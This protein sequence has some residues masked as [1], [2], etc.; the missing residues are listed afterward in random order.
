MKNNWISWLLTGCLLIGS[1]TTYADPLDTELQ[2]SIQ[3]YLNQNQTSLHISAVQ[4]SVWLPTE[5]Q[6]RDYV[7]GAQYYNQATPATK[8][9]MMQWG[10]VTKE[11]TAAL[12]FQLINQGKLNPN[13]TLI[14]LF[15][16]QFT[17]DNSDAW[18]TAWANVTLV[19]LMNMTSGITNYTSIPN[20]IPGVTIPGQYSLQYLVNRTASYQ[21][22]NGC[23]INVG[24]FTPAGKEWFYSNTNYL[25]L[26]LVVEKITGLSFTDAINQNIL[27]SFQNKGDQVYYY[28]SEYPA[29]I[30][31]QMIHGYMFSGYG[32][33]PLT[34]LQDVTNW[35]MSFG[36]SAGA[37]IGNMNALTK[38]TYALYNNQIN[39]VTI[40]ELQQNLVEIPS[41][42]PVNQNNIQTQCVLNSDPHNHDGSCYAMGL[43]ASYDPNHQQTIWWYEGNTA[44]Y[45]TL[46]IW[47]P[48]EKVVVAISQ[49]GDERDSL[50][51][52]VL[53]TINPYI[54]QYLSSTQASRLNIKKK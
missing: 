47:F 35:N 19:Q 45:A 5:S 21:N 50:T 36:A 31:A 20:F 48:N 6:P 26:G 14:Q 3:T 15:P 49:N 22:Q 4:L 34:Q 32:T 16:E 28:A 27:E 1:I 43:F 38:T 18:P 30:L 2:N 10:S 39:N 23:S 17:Q 9:M 51:A 52:L 25:I 12:I 53:N 54:K 46:Y 41:G 44:G 7:V 37:M 13:D 8:D 40:N 11:Y 29:N 42:Q 24:C 33:N